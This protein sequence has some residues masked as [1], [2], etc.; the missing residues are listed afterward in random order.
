MNTF[1]IYLD[2][3]KS[4]TW[5]KTDFCICAMCGKKIYVYKECYIVEEYEEGSF[6]SSA[7]ACSLLCVNM[8]I[9]SKI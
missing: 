7:Y 4:N 3:Q 5:S 6:Y 8:Y 9:L 1:T 2:H